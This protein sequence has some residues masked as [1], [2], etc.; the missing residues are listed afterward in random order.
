V[1]ELSIKTKPKKILN[2]TRCGVDDIDE[3]N[4]ML[5]IKNILKL[6]GQ[7]LV[8]G[9]EAN[10][11]YEG[12]HNDTYIFELVKRKP[13]PIHNELCTIMLERT[14][15]KIFGQPGLAYYFIYNSQRTNVCASADW[16]A[17]KDNMIER[18][19]YMIMNKENI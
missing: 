19:E 11:I 15:H 5:T 14:G 2:S 13:Y 6:Q 1:A 12:N 8:D 4:Y 17:D 16:L 9:W 7:P 10:H 3:L 18:L